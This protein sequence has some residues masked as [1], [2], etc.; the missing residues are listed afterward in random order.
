MYI[1]D[2]RDGKVC[3]AWDDGTAKYWI[4]DWQFHNDNAPAVIYASGRCDYYTNGKFIKS[5][6]YS[7][8]YRISSREVR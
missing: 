1:I 3:F 7:N 5:V 2:Y 4:K 6:E 8:K